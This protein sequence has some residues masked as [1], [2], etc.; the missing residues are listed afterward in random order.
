MKTAVQLMKA[1]A[2]QT[3]LRL[4][5]ALLEG[6]SCVC[7]LSDALEVEQSNLSRHLAALRA[8]GVLESRK[9]GTWIYYSVAREERA[10]LRRLLAALG[11]IE[12]ERTRLDAARLRKRHA[13]REKGRCCLGYG[14]LPRSRKGKRS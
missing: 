8:A 1:L 2:E 3:R 6:E 7:E 13:M 14:E 9:D 4:A 12:D 5:V 10:R 11:E